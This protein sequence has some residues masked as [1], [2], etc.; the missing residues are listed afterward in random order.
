MSSTFSGLR[1]G[2]KAANV[3][4]GSVVLAAYGTFDP[5]STAQV[6][7]FTLPAGAIPLGVAGDGGATGGTNPTVVVGTGADDDGFAA[8][9]DAD[10]PS[11]G[12]SGALTGTE[13]TVNTEVF[14]KVG[15]SAA[16]GGTVGV[17]MTYVLSDSKSGAW[18]PG[19]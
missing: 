7:L 18:N 9:M 19:A 11:V 17:T 16:T 15:A 6:S 14:G 3:Y 5:T 4:H 12:N 10:A 2:P 1:V 13:I 8:A